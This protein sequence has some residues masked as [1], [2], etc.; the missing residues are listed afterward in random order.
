MKP[1]MLFT[2]GGTVIRTHSRRRDVAFTAIGASLVVAAIALGAWLDDTPAARLVDQATDELPAFEQGRAAGRA[3][4]MP[5]VRDAYAAGVREG[6]VSAQDTPQGMQ[7]AQACMACWY[8]P[9]I[10]KADLRAKLCAG[11]RP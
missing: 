5:T 10:R 2:P 6:L 1:R 11:S 4:L 9:R 8:E 3:E 7:L